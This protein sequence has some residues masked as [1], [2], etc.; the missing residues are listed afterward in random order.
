MK[1]VLTFCL[2]FNSL[3]PA[4]GTNLFCKKL[5]RLIY[6]IPFQSADLSI[7]LILYIQSIL[8]LKLLS[9]INPLLLMSL[10]YSILLLN[11]LNSRILTLPF[12]AFTEDQY[13]H[14]NTKS[15]Y[16]ILKTKYPNLKFTYS[17]LA[18]LHR[19]NTEFILINCSSTAL[20]KALVFG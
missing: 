3:V 10:V 17:F 9:M 15:R 8:L 13:N 6:L 11:R 18:C 2:D 16:T 12:V 20:R 1:K 7:C 14:Y 4:Y 5:F 19:Y